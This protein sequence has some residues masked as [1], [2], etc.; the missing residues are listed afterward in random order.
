MLRTHFAHHKKT[1][2]RLSFGFCHCCWSIIGPLYLHTVHR[3]FL[4]CTHHTYT[5]LCVCLSG[6]TGELCKNDRTIWDPIWWYKLMWAEGTLYFIRGIQP[7]WLGAISGIFYILATLSAESRCVCKNAA[8]RKIMVAVLLVCS[9]V[10]PIV[11]HADFRL[12]ACMNPATDVGKKDLPLGIRNRY[13]CVCSIFYSCLLLCFFF[14]CCLN[15]DILKC[16]RAS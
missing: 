6:H 13:W 15:S 4:F 12:F 2:S 11:R 1:R 16:I 7:L 9:D 10:L 14:L 8:W 5:G 3:C